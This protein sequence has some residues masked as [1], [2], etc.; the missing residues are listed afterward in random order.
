[1]RQKYLPAVVNA[2]HVAGYVLR[3]KFED[4]KQRIV[5]ISQWFRGPVFELLRNPAFFKKFFLQGATIA[6]PNGAD[7][8]PEALYDAPESDLRQVDRAPRRKPSTTRA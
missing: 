2:S 6:W 4:G 7:V 1:M 3:I 8:S 5:D